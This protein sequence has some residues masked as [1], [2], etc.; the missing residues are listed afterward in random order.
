MSGS[1][2]TQAAASIPEVRD[3]PKWT[4]MRLVIAEDNTLIRTGLRLLVETLPDVR[5][6]GEAAFGADAVELIVSLQPDVAIMDISLP[7]LSGLEAIRRVGKLAPDV[8]II[9]ISCDGEEA[10]VHKALSAGARAYM[11]KDS[12]VSQLKA[13]L[14]SAKAGQVYLS[15]CVRTP[16][17]EAMIARGNDATPLDLL[18]SRQREVLQLVAE[19][20]S[21]KEIAARLDLSIKTVETHRGAIMQRLGLRD[22]TGLVRFAMSQGLVANGHL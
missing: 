2:P 22:V 10:S 5:V 6:V 3:V 21:T 14:R 12:D 19:G 4:A 11:G 15:S 8:P 9:V 17:L 1:V 16:M 7:G 13:A 20:N 18:T